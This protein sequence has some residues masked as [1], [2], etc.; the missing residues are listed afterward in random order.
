M[1][2]KPLHIT[3]SLTI[4]IL[5]L[6]G[7]SPKQVEQAYGVLERDRVVLTATANEIITSLPVARGSHVKEGQVL[8]QLGTLQ[9][10]AKLARA[11][12]E[13]AKAEAFLLKLVN[14]ER[15]EDIAFAQAQL[16][17]AQV[18]LIES[19]KKYQRVLGLI[20]ESL[21]SYAQKDTAQAQRD[22]AQADYHSS[23]E[24]LDKL[25]SGERPEVIKQ[26]QASLEAADAEVTLQQSI[27]DD[28]TVV[29]TRG[30]IL[31]S[32]PFNVGERV[33]QNAIVAVI[34]ADS[35]PYARVYIPENKRVGLNV[36]DVRMLSIN[37]ADSSIEGRIRW[38]ASEPAFTPYYTLSESSRSRLMYLAEFSLPESASALPSG[39]AVKV[40]L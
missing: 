30:G 1:S 26:A 3:F 15:R 22:A 12:A 20:E 38:I 40:S 33:P 17:H 14:G 19:K 8:V 32:L 10:N 27:L 34:Q 11:K 35:V 28:L 29:A 7:C 2:V 6:I 13:S 31:D 18:N 23:K 25:I 16:R 37:G 5:L 24:K 9:Q 36:G 21:T 39:I 4:L